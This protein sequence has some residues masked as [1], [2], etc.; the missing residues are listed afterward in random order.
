MKKRDAYKIATDIIREANLPMTRFAYTQAVTPR[1]AMR[2]RAAI[3][4]ALLLCARPEQKK[5]RR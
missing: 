5:P 4:K 1:D 2:L 3:A